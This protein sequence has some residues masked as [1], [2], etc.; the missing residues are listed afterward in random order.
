MN[1]SGLQL[2]QPSYLSPKMKWND[3]AACS[4]QV[5]LTQQRNNLLSYTVRLKTVVK[6]HMWLW[7]KSSKA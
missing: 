3:P 2:Q 4:F 1:Y 5:K 6:C 7:K